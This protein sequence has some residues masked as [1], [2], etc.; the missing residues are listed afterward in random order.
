MGNQIFGSLYI[1]TIIIITIISASAEGISAHIHTSTWAFYPELSIA[2]VE[3]YP[4]RSLAD[5]MQISCRRSCADPVRIRPSRTLFGW[6][7]KGQFGPSFA[8]SLGAFF[9]QSNILHYNVLSFK[10]ARRFGGPIELYNFKISFRCISA[11]ISREIK[12]ATQNSWRKRDAATFGG[13]FTGNRVWLSV[14][15]WLCGWRRCVGGLIFGSIVGNFTA[16][17][18]LTCHELSQE[19]K[20]GDISLLHMLHLISELMII[21][22]FSGK[23]FVYSPI[24]LPSMALCWLVN[25]STD[26]QTYSRY[27]DT[28]KDF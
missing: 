22:F 24:Q 19:A 26:L 9:W 28:Q 12:F 4:W 27:S 6:Q 17:Y 14:G 15:G 1:P 25:A 21:I 3:V 10:T 5:P 7:T 8:K 20:G 13:T 2:G 16:D 23:S 11:P 18:Q